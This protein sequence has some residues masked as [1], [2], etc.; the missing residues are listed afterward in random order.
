MFIYIKD[1]IHS[2]ALSKKTIH[3]LERRVLTYMPKA[4]E[5]MSREDVL[6]S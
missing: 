2:L 5:Q 4:G 6:S 3:S 1:T